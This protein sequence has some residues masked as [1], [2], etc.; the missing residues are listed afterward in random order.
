M[1]EQDDA[2]APISSDDDGERERVDPTPAGEPLAIGEHAKLGLETLDG[3]MPPRPYA[4]ESTASAG[5]RGVDSLLPDHAA[6]SGPNRYRHESTIGADERKRV[7]ETAMYPWRTI[8]QLHI[9]SRTG[10]EFIGTGWLIGPR[11]I[12]T[13]GH[14]LYL[15]ELGGWA[16]RIVVT[17]A[18]NG[19]DRPFSSVS[20]TKFHSV[21]GW[22]VDGR[23]EH[24]YG[25]IWLPED[26]ALPEIGTFG[27]S[28]FETPKLVGG[29]VNLAGY[30]ADKDD[31]TTLWWS[32]RR[33]LSV[34]RDVLH[35]DADT[36]AGQSGA[37]VWRLDPSSGRRVAVGIHT[38]GA[39][40]GNSAV[41]INHR[42]FKNLCD[43]SQ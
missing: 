12:V 27:Y 32:A 22:T 9:F 8:C 40:T 37:P 16:D 10:D 39:R 26:Q 31:G 42:V 1:S 28:I 11:T 13:A 20:T 7:H 14:C 5:V 17:P 41:R 6:P 3:W 29:Y 36:A 15:P 38:N 19:N 23:R 4:R 33:S 25:V 30:P 24:D 35:Y 21:R 43:W 18:R 2:H 34:D